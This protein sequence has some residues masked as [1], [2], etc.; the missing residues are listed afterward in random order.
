MGVN[1]FGEELQ[2]IPGQSQG[3][4]QVLDD[5]LG[6]IGGDCPGEDGVVRSEV[7]MHPLDQLVPQPTGE[8]QVDVGKLGRVLGDE[9]LQGQVPSEGV[10][11]ANADE[12]AHQE[13]HRGAPAPPRRTLLQ[14]YLEDGPS[15]SP[16]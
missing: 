6:R 5:A 12:V 9:P 14:G 4:A 10:H 2:V 1:L 3:L 13:G 11:V 16:P 8:V 7:L 15:P